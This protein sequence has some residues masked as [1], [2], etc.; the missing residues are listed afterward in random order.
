MD[1]GHKAYEPT[2]RAPQQITDAAAQSDVAL[3]V[4]GTGNLLHRFDVRD[5]QRGSARCDMQKLPTV[6]TSLMKPHARLDAARS[7]GKHSAVLPEVQRETAMRKNR[8]P[9]R[10]RP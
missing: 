8:E 3:A 10:T 1:D 9:A 6:G 2:R 7:R 4:N 5:R